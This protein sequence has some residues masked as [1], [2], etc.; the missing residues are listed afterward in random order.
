MSF[1]R[2]Q[3]L[4]FQSTTL[5]IQPIPETT[6]PVPLGVTAGQFNKDDVAKL[7]SRV[8]VPNTEPEKR[9]IQPM[10]AFTTH[11]KST[12][13]QLEQSKEKFDMKQTMS[14]SST[15]TKVREYSVPGVYNAWHVSVDKSGR[16]WVSDWGGN[17][18]QTDLQGNLLQEIQTNCF[19]FYNYIFIPLSQKIY[20]ACPQR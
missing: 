15:V 3:K 12:E 19:L 11:M 5:K 1:K 8:N 7:L 9:K 17:L 14:L 18:V 10:E 13:K 20:P 4:L 6:K 16:L 2:N